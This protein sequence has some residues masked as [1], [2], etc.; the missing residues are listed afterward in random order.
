MD[1]VHSP[2]I[3]SNQNNDS[4]FQ[5]LSITGIGDPS[6]GKRILCEGDSWM[7]IG[8][9]PSS[10]M[11]EPLK[12]SQRTLLLNLA[13]P[14][15][16]VKNM[17]EIAGNPDLGKMIN[18]ARLSHKWDL[19]FISGGGNDLIDMSESIVCTP[20]VGAGQ[21][22]LDYIDRVE[23]ARFRKRLHEGY[24]R[25]S[26][27]RTKSK[28]NAETPIA[29]HVYDYPTPRNAKSRF[30]GHNISGPWLFRAMKTSDVPKAFW[31]PITDYI[32]EELGRILLEL[33]LFLPN[34]HVI[35]GTREVLTRARL[36]TTGEDGDWL[37]EIHPTPEGYEKLSKIISPEI[38]ALL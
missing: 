17:S 14:G 31:I 1:M 23:L 19:I 30:L 12:F 38:Q 21:N 18:D 37:N 27:L 20:S 4:Y 5:S 35:T 2:V 9:V 3:I 28:N 6:F 36:D 25:I 24:R 15:D 16:T 7:S 29:V 10:N 32:F 34:F 22:F 11:L 8:A 33:E 13:K 26:D